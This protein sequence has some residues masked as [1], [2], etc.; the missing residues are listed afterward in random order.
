MDDSYL[1]LFGKKKEEL[2]L[3]ENSLVIS[4]ELDEEAD[5]FEEEK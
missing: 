4:F 3:E 1:L 5:K 2:P